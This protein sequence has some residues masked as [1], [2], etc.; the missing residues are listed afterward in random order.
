MDAI[1]VRNLPLH[2]PVILNATST[3]KQLAHAM[4]TNNIGSVLV[5]DETGKL[6]GIVT[7]RDV[8][9]ALAFQKI[10]AGDPVHRLLIDKKLVYV[11]DEATLHDVVDLMRE[12]KIRRMPVVHES[13]GKQK[14]IGIVTLDDLIKAKMLDDSDERSILRAQLDESENFKPR[15]RAPFRHQDKRQDSYHS[16]IKSVADATH[17]SRG[18]ARNLILYLMTTVLRR[19]TSNEGKH[20][21]SQFPYIFQMELI[22]ELD[23]DEIIDSSEIISEIGRRFNKTPEESV[24]LLREAW[25]AIGQIISPGETSKVSLHLP[26]DMRQVFLEHDLL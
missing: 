9:F 13:N 4:Q 21:I 22:P 7:D 19:I 3:L 6:V 18:D 23:S 5:N 26:K 15:P 20:L 17:L 16:F 2:R 24:Q 14:C 25:T 11:T 8:A 12:E 1:G 10:K